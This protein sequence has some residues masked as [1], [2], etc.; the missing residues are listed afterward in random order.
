MD[1]ANQYQSP[2]ENADT[3]PPLSSNC[4]F[5]RPL[6]LLVK[7]N[8]PFKAACSITLPFNAIEIIY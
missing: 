4:L 3:V 1:H 7:K 6:Q 5:T 8:L 2:Q